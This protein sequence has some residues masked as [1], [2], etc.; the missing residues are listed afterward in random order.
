MC[1]FFAQQENEIDAEAEQKRSPSMRLR[2]GRRN[3]PFMSLLNEVGAAAA[4]NFAQL[5]ALFALSIHQ[6]EAM[7]YGNEPLSRKAQRTPSVRL[8]FGKR[9]DA[10]MLENEVSEKS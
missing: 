2:F 8:R 3:D 4:C 1:V 10:T 9:S 5:D 7:L 6:Q